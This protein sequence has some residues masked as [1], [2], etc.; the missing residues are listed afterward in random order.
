M[1]D[2]VDLTELARKVS[3]LVKKYEALYDE[4]TKTVNGLSVY[5]IAVIEGF[6]GTQAEFL[7]TLVGPQGPKGDK[8]NEDR[9]A[10][11]L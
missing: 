4:K 7:A 11:G 5:D 3:I 1:P 10:Q 6:T 9:G 2:S 8:G